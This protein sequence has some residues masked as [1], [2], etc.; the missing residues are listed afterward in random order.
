MKTRFTPRITAVFVA[1]LAACA[2]VPALACSDHGP[3][4]VAPSPTKPV[5]E[6]GSLSEAQFAELDAY[7]A[8]VQEQLGA[9]REDQSKFDFSQLDYLAQVDKIRDFN[10]RAAQIIR[11]LSDTVSFQTKI[12]VGNGMLCGASIEVFLPPAPDNIEFGRDAIRTYG[13]GS[14]GNRELGLIDTIYLREE[15]AKLRNPQEKN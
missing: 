10:Q 8:A 12:T 11:Q 9:L 13:K 1:A 7:A 14:S 3:R 15:L 4:Y 5:V 2:S 6:F